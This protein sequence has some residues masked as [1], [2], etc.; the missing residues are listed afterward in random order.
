MRWGIVGTGKIAKGFASGLVH[1]SQAQPYAIASRSLERSESFCLDTGIAFEKKFGSYAELMAD[2]H[3][4]TVYIATPHPMHMESIELALKAGKPVL[5]EKPMV[6]NASEAVKAFRLARSKQVLLMEAMWMRF[7][8]AMQHCSSIISS[9]VLG[10]V[11]SVT[12]SLRIRLSQDPCERLLNP[13]LGGGAL[14]DLGVYPLH[15]AA[16]C[17]GM[18]T[19]VKSSMRRSPITGVDV[20]NFMLCGFPN[21]GTAS[22]SC[23]SDHAARNEAWIVGEHGTILIREPFW[24]PTTLEIHRHGYPC[25]TVSIPYQSS[26]LQY[27][28]LHFEKC[29]REGLSESPVLTEALTTGVLRIIDEIRRE[30]DFSY[31]GEIMTALSGKADSKFEA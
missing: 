3:V 21:G 18:P 19:A 7:L 25:E 20:E 9:G 10:Q 23:A 30:H 5:C 31:P 29:V 16:M 2:P 17:F 6:M 1:L 27:Q 12:A 11:T 15:L 28:V 4:E 24:H 8:P 22:L 26:G 14:L 13:N